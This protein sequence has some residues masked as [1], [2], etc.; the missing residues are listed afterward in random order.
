M[1]RTQS[2]SGSTSLSLDKYFAM[3]YFSCSVLPPPSPPPHLPSGNWW[4]LVDIPQMFWPIGRRGDSSVNLLPFLSTYLISR[5][6]WDNLKGNTVLQGKGNQLT[7]NTI[8]F[9]SNKYAPVF[10]NGY[11]TYCLFVIYGKGWLVHVD[12]LLSVEDN[13]TRAQ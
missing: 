5:H 13:L 3:L 12:L 7:C 10:S 2:S 1:S 6:S 4:K 9:A 8:F 11:G